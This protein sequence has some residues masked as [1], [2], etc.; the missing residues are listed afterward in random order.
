MRIALFNSPAK[1]E[2]R[3][4]PPAIRRH[5][6]FTFIGWPATRSGSQVATVVTPLPRPFAMPGTPVVRPRP[7]VSLSASEIGFNLLISIGFPTRRLCQGAASSGRFVALHPS[8]GGPPPPAVA[9]VEAIPGIDCEIFFALL[10]QPYREL[11]DGGCA[12]KEAITRTLG[13]YC[14]NTGPEWGVTPRKQNR[15]F[16]VGVRHKVWY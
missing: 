8:D 15:K 7:G 6:V 16:E 3:T 13:K 14:R 1:C 9:V 4:A 11:S 5:S 10:Q 2:L 12:G